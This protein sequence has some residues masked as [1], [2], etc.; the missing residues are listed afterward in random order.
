MEFMAYNHMHFVFNFFAMLFYDD[1]IL[2]FLFLCFFFQNLCGLTNTKQ[3]YSTFFV[4]LFCVKE[5]KRQKFLSNDFANKQIKHFISSLM[6]IKNGK[7]GII[8]NEH[9]F[10]NLNK[11]SESRNKI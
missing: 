8:R 6:I 1:F 9:T 3:Q 4:Q 11:M 7:K 10:C 5:K 2:F